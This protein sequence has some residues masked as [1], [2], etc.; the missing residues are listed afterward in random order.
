MKNLMAVVAFLFLVLLVGRAAP[1]GNN[2]G[3]E[4]R[5][6]P[7]WKTVFTAETRKLTILEFVREGDDIDRWKE[8]VT[9]ENRGPHKSSP[10]KIFNDLKALREKECPGATEWNVIEKKESSVLYE[11]HANPCLGWPEQ[12]EIARIISGTHDLFVLHYAAKVHALTAD[13]R[14]QWIKTFS[15]ATLDSEAGALVPKA[16]R[17]DVDEVVPFG[18]DKVLAALKPAMESQNCNVSESTADRIECKRPRVFANNRQTSGG[19]SVTA[20]LEAKG[21]QTQVRITTGLGFYGRLAKSNWSTPIYEQLVKR[22]QEARLTPTTIASQ[23]G[24]SSDVTSGAVQDKTPVVYA[25]W[26]YNPAP[27]AR[28]EL[29]ETE[30]KNVKG[31]PS[32]SYYLESAGFPPGNTYRLWT[33]ESGD[34][35]TFAIFGGYTADATGKLICPGQTQ[36][37]GPTPK[38][39]RCMPLEHVTLD[40]HAYHKG[41]PVDFAAV[42]TDGMVRAY[43]RAD[44]FPI[45]AQD[46]KCTLNVEIENTKFT[47]FV[48]RGAGF[49]QGENVT[50]SSNFGNDAT[51]GTQQASAQGEFSAAIHA[52]LPGKNSG[53]ATFSATGS[54]CHPTITFEWG[55]AAMKLQ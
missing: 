43:A 32:F 13:A 49:A 18:I 40:F 12:V 17:D 39:S 28:L 24:V 8:L 52:D 33:M 20:V 45:Q 44:P 36:L 7:E 54:S 22:L 23:A 26:G 1:E 27:G 50:T 38:G 51:A 42:S 35:R 25:N 46:G 15:E 6:E 31:R 4:L 55:K 11:W 5:L 10:E 3:V 29:K 47:S 53:S 34:H 16:G 37:G 2:E 30:R 19:E 41:E 9:I 14:A 21:D 48:I